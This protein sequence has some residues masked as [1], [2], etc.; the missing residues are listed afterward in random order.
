MGLPLAIVAFTVLGLAAAVVIANLSSTSP[1]DAQIRE[2]DK[3]GHDVEEATYGPDIHF[4]A[5]GVDFGTVPLNKEVSYAFSVANVGNE[6]LR[7][8][9]V[10]VRVIEGC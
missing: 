6:T 4:A 8:S 9:D 2:I 3:V 10:R 7:I 5:R 1:E